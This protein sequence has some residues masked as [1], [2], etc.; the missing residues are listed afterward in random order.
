[1]DSGELGPFQGSV[2]VQD[3]GDSIA[4]LIPGTGPSGS[5]REL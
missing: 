5:I 1:M 3:R 2:D 4:A